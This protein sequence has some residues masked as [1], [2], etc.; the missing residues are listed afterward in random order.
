MK[1]IHY[2]RRALIAPLVFLSA[3]AWGTSQKPPVSNPSNSHAEEAP[4]VAT[5]SLDEPDPLLRLSPVEPAPAAEMP[6]G[7]PGMEPGEVKPGEMKPGEMKPGEMKPGEMKRG[8]MKPIEM[9]PAKMNH[10]GMNHGAK[11]DPRKSAP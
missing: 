1:A 3:C 4:F 7:M 11:P 6:A 10:G 8:E 9:N 5:T 2:G